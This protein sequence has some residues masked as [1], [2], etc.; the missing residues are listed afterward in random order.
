M[1][2]VKYTSELGRFVACD[3]NTGQFR[4]VH[5]VSNPSRK[6]AVVRDGSARSIKVFS[7]KQSA[8][9]YAREYVIS[10]NGSKII[11]HDRNGKIDELVTVSSSSPSRKR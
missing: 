8:I 7:R 3:A 11:I 4:S 5:V 10:K 2:H 1:K 9:S 6:W